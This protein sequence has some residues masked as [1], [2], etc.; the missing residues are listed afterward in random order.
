MEMHATT[1]NIPTR[2]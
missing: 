1:Y 2:C